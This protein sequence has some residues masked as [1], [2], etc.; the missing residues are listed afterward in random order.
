MA[1]ARSSFVQPEHRAWLQEITS[2]PTAAGREDRVIDW[3]AGWVGERGDLALERD[4]AGNLT[5]RGREASAEGDPVYI[6][7]HLDHPAFVV[8]RVEAERTL[9]AEFRGGVM[10]DYFEGARVRAHPAEGEAVCGRVAAEVEAAGSPHKHYRLEMDGPVAAQAGDVV[11]WDLAATEIGEDGIVRAPACDDLAAVAAAV[12][13]MD[14]LRT[15]RAQG[16]AVQETRLL[17]T[18]AEEIGF[19][20]AIAACREGTMP[21]GS[22]VI[23]LENSRSFV[24]SPIG[25]GPILRIGDRM[26]V[27]DPRLTGAIAG[28]AEEA[29]GRPA[30][31]RASD[32]AS[33]ATGRPWQRKLMPGGACEATVFCHYG[34]EATCVCLPLGNYHNMAE[35]DAVQAGENT[36]PARIDREYISTRDYDGLIDLLVACGRS[37]EPASGL[38]DRLE[39]LWEERRGVVGL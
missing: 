6:T 17:F 9:V 27:F 19:I 2:L 13:A 3:I 10:D 35:L 1:E 30:H 39:R 25:G 38:D 4:A 29:F 16:E 14:E 26:S 34:Y 18:R 21:R 37:L 15:L 36:E 32:K 22:R 23:A 7:A 20:G 11:V 12:S 5:I 8:E 33:E 28:R 31:L 24:D